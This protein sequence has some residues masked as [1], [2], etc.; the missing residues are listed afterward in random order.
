M[1]AVL[2]LSNISQE[3]RI[4]RE[5]DLPGHVCVPSLDGHATIVSG[6]LAADL[7]GYS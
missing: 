7:Q 6:K 5:R 3:A 1:K 2:P 4:C